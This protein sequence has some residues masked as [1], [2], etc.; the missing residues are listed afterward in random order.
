MKKLLYDIAPF[1][2]SEKS[3]NIL[4]TKKMV[5]TA[6][7]TPESCITEAL[8][9]ILTL[10]YNRFSGTVFIRADEE[11]ILKTANYLKT[12]YDYK[13]MKPSGFLSYKLPELS[14]L[15][16]SENLPYIIENFADFSSLEIHFTKSES[17][18]FVYESVKN[19]PYKITAENLSDIL[20]ERCV[21]L[22]KSG[23][24]DELECIIKEQYVQEVLDV[25][26]KYFKADKK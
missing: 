8:K 23:D 13:Q 17:I 12:D 2:L 1:Y 6:V 26:I 20:R 11:T 16:S 10:F 21:I 9:E 5:G 3:I 15:L 24:A 14:F 19:H 7:C 25:F 22:N 18:G 4:H